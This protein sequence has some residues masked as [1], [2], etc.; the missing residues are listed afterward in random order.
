MTE[1][2]LI[3]FNTISNLRTALDEGIFELFNKFISDSPNAIKR[4][5]IAVENMDT[6][7]IAK[8]AHYL[9]G[10]AGNI[11][12]IALSNACKK[13]EILATNNDTASMLNQVDELKVIYSA[14]TRYM[15][16]QSKV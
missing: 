9:K 1:S 3:D 8:A 16:R 10:S 4:I 7:E 13:L 14:T 2:D 15:Q 5:D 12:A 11:G 6:Q